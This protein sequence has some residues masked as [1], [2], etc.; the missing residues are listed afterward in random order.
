MRVV[1]REKRVVV[2]ADVTPHTSRVTVLKRSLNLVTFKIKG[3]FSFL[4][5]SD[6]HAPNNKRDKIIH[7]FTPQSHLIFGMILFVFVF[8][9]PMCLCLETL[10]F[11]AFVS[12]TCAME[13]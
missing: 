5:F 1:E 2:T 4:F 8:V 11:P 3:F 13:E 10:P 7:N 6:V 12:F 9:S